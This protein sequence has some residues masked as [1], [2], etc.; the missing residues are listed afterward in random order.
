[1]RIP[2]TTTPQSGEYSGQGEL[3]FK[4]SE[5]TTSTEGSQL[6]PGKTSWK[7]WCFRETL[8][9]KRDLVRGT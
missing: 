8:K 6:Q 1:M 9:H 7:R 4:V 2:V 5:F 3:Q